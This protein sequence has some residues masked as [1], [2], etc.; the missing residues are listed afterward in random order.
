MGGSRWLHSPAKRA[1]DI[2]AA[3]GALVVVSPI[4]AVVAVLVRL[5]LGSPVLFRQERAGLAGQPFQVVKFRTMTHDHDHHGELL[6]DAGGVAGSV[7]Q[8]RC[9]HGDR[10]RSPRLPIGVA[11]NHSVPAELLNKPTIRPAME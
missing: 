5:R 10:E 1:F 4:I 2:V 3:G 9:G 11:T 6:S 8:E 7:E